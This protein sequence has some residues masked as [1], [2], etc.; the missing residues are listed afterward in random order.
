MQKKGWA[1]VEEYLNSLTEANQNKEHL[2]K[3]IVELMSK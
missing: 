2:S 1:L 3:K